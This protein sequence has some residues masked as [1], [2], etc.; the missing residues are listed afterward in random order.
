MKSSG[1]YMDETLHAIMYLTK[2]NYNA[3]ISVK[4]IREL[5]D[6]DS[7]NHSKVNFYWRNLQFLEQIGILKTISTKSPKLYKVCNFFKFF[8][9]LHDSYMCNYQRDLIEAVI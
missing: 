4:R 8:E 6:I 2:I 5:Y 1:K 3:V 7:L 9:L